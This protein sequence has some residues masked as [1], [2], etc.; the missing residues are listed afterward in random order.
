MDG[1]AGVVRRL[2]ER[3]GEIEDAIFAR[4]CAVVSDPV[5]LGDAEYLA[6]LRAAVVAAVDYGL[7]GIERAGE[8][9]EPVPA[10]AVSQ[11]RRAARSGV[12]LD[13]MLRRYTAGYALLEDFVIQEVERA[14]L[15][16]QS[17]ALRHVLRAHASVLERLTASIAEEYR[18]ELEQAGRSPER[19]LLERVQRLLA[20]KAQDELGG[21]SAPGALDSE[22]GYELEGE[23]VGVIACGE[24]GRE[25]VCS[26]AVRLDRRLLSVAHG[27]R[28]IWTWLGGRRPLAMAE[29]QRVVSAQESGEDV[30][31]AVGEPARGLEGWRL[32]HRQAQAA[33]SVALRRPQGLTRYGDVALLATALKDETLAKTLIDVYVAPLNDFRDGGPALRETLRGYLTAERNVSAAAAELKVARSTVES[34][35]RT[36]EARLGRSLHACPAELEIALQLDGLRGL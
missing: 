34:R 21:A 24:G 27:E 36:I 32:T 23:H 1:V 30:S 22:L 18:A 16:S 28:T 14:N 9:P 2:R 33:L 10:A 6:G 26:L 19:R 4:V 25:L 11:A 15:A 29:L 35:L 7:M 3:R 17:G 8:L 5:G 12:N 31:L 13:T 20:G